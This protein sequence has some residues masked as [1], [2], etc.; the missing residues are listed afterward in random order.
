L[1][2]RQLLPDV[3]RLHDATQVMLRDGRQHLRQTRELLRVEGMTL[4]HA[5]VLLSDLGRHRGAELHGHGALMCFQEAE[6][7]QAPAWYAL[8]K[9][10][11]WQRKYQ[12]AAELANRGFE[13]GPVTPMSVQLASYE[14]NSA[15]LLGDVR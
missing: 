12:V 5:S 9:T 7:S 11:R 4:A 14:A 2:A 3:L 1:P 10:A 6:A 8:A 15:A 13:A